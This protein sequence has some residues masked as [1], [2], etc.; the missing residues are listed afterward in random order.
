MCSLDV[1]SQCKWLPCPDSLLEVLTKWKA[2]IAWINL[3]MS[4]GLNTVG[5]TK[6]M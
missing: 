4:V 2:T 1:L 3:Q 5:D 6:V